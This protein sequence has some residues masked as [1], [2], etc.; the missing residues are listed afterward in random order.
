MRYLLALVCPPVA[1]L[2]GGR[3]WQAV[4][5]LVIDLIGLATIRW[6]VGYLAI[7]GCILW[8]MNMVS[9]DLA[10]TETDQFVRSVKPIKMFRN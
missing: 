4:L 3:R 9:E 2:A 10:R 7:C 1:L 6:G 8:A 5:A